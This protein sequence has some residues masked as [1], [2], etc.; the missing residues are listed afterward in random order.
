M[1]LKLM[2]T[3]LMEVLFVAIV[4]EKADEGDADDGYDILTIQMM[5]VVVEMDDDRGGKYQICW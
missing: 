3:S 2:A 4:M 1:V 5:L